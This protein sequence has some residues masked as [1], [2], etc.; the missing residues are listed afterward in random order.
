MALPIVCLIVFQLLINCS[1]DPVRSRSA[2]E[3]N[4][5]SRRLVSTLRVIR[6][7]PDF[8]Q[9]EPTADI[10]SDPA[11]TESVPLLLTNEDFSMFEQ[12][13]INQF[14]IQDQ[15]SSFIVA[16]SSDEAEQQPQ[17]VLQF[18]PIN[19]PIPEPFIS[20]DGPQPFPEIQGTPVAAPEQ[21]ESTQGLEN[22]SGVDLKIVS[23]P[24]PTI[25]VNPPPQQQP[26]EELIPEQPSSPVDPSLGY[27]APVPV[28]TPVPIV[29]SPENVEPIVSPLS[30]PADPSELVKLEEVVVVAVPSPQDP[31][32]PVKVEL[33]PASGYQS[34]TQQTDKKSH[35]KVLAPFY[36]ILY[37]IAPQHSSYSVGPQVPYNQAKYSPATS[38]G[39]HHQ[40][41]HPTKHGNDDYP[42]RQFG[43]PPTPRAL[44]FPP[45]SNTNDNLR[46]EVNWD[47]VGRAY[48][49]TGSA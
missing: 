36:G 44:G 12:S 2:N 14:P 4:R 32:I 24:F 10:E 9:V 19:E 47:R 41:D 35:Y 20:I 42:R 21:V 25:L 17:Q 45:V 40:P 3:K 8:Q 16:P 48:R 34:L 5:S 46:H 28:S 23:E 39:S 49:S 29:E 6:N 38:Y 18:N 33:S 26:T 30:S 31:S 27:L 11:A 1:A 43:F 22:F 7:D 13:S 15:I 37:P